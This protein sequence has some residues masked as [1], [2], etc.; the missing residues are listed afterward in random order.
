MFRRSTAGC[1]A[2]IRYE[3]GW[4]RENTDRQAGEGGRREGGGGGGGGGNI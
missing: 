2:S 1:L 3:N 4:R